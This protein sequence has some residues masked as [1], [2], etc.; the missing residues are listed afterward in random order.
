M[1]GPNQ[2]GQPALQDVI[3]RN[4]LNHGATLLKPFLDLPGTNPTNSHFEDDFL[5]FIA[6]Y[7]LPTP[8]INHPLN[9]KIV[10]VYFPDHNLIVELD[11]WEYHKDRHAFETDRERDAHQ[12][13]HGIRTLRITKERLKANPDHE[14]QRLQQILDQ[15]T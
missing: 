14:A 9:G 13:A 8:L 10:D 6:K 3:T 1:P 5:A 15:A 4:H 7:G 12:L 11:G 2:F